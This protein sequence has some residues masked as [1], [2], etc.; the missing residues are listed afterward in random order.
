MRVIRRA[1]A[2]GSTGGQFEGKS[3]LAADGNPQQSAVVAVR[4][5][6][7]VLNPGVKR[8][9]GRAVDIERK[10]SAF[11]P[12]EYRFLNRDADEPLCVA[13]PNAIRSRCLP[14]ARSVEAGEKLAPIGRV[15]CKRG[16]DLAWR[17]AHVNGGTKTDGGRVEEQCLKSVDWLGKGRT[18]PGD[19]MKVPS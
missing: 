8:R 10:A 16:E 17:S 4:L 12:D 9:C 1:K 3:R 18:F 11:V 14:T 13:R 15:M 6:V 5:K 19:R 2:R 7:V